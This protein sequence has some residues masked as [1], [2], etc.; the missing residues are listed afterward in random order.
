MASGPHKRILHLGH[1]WLGIGLA[2]LMLLWFVSGLIMLFIARPQLSDSERLAALPALSAA[3][4]R[5]S[6]RQAWH[7][8]RLPGAPEALRLNVAASGTAYRILAQ[9]TW[10]SID[11]S[12]GTLL[13]P[14]DIA[15][16]RQS[17]ERH[18]SQTAIHRLRPIHIDQWTLYRR[19]DAERPFWRAELVDGRH[20]YFSSRTHQIALD[21]SRSERIWNWL[22]SV[23]HWIYIT[24]LRQN[25]PLWRQIVL[26]VSSFALILVVSGAWLGWQ[27]WRLRMPYRDGRSSPYRKRWK[28]WHHLFGLACALILFG[29]LLSGWLSLAPLGWAGNTAKKPPARA[30]DI[31]QLTLI[32]E[33]AAGTREIE[34]SQLGGT[35][36]RNDKSATQSFIRPAGF[37]PQSQLSLDDITNALRGIPDLQIAQA[38]WQ[39][40]ADSRYFPLRHHP[41]SFPV[42]RITLADA[43]VLYISPHNGRIVASAHPN[44]FAQRW[45][46]HGLHR[47]DFPM[48]INPPWLRELLVVLL[49]LVGIAF[50]L[51]GIA[52]A[53]SRLSRTTGSVGCA[54]QNTGG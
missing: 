17:I 45:L 4:I 22:G 38:H 16:A 33:I 1:R 13:P 28:R 18:A 35:L 27:R 7:A 20:F 43:S 15:L 42:A 48:L 11:A 52:L 30:L 40:E 6:P 12:S 29:W 19:F 10:H 41:R 9:Q 51:T 31:E 5:I 34:W 23:S 54:K 44:D 46:Y 2:L 32:P 8:L 49:S 25:P 47:L 3:D 21:S 37:A 39:T 36:L 24:P 50:C 53:W 14:G 26:W